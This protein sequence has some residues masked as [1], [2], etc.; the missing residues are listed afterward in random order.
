M[1]AVSVRQSVMRVTWLHC[2]KA[3]GRIKMLFGTNTAGGP[4]NIVLD[5][6]L[7]IPLQRKSKAVREY[8]PTTYLHNG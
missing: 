7:L 8:G 1:I 3:A 4:W 5:V 6:G 2:A